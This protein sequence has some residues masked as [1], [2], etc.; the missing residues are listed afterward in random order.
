MKNVFCLKK[1]HSITEAKINY[2]TNSFVHPKRKMAEHDFIYMLEGE[3]KLG[4][5]NNTYNLEKDSLII[6]GANNTH[7]NVSPCLP[8]TKT[9]HF[10]VSCENGDGFVEKDSEIPNDSVYVDIFF[11]FS[12]NKNV[13]KI[14]SEIVSQKLSGNQTKANILFD[15]LLLELLKKQD[16]EKDNRIEFKIKKIIH[17]NPEKFFSNN[18]LAKMVNVS[19]KTAESKFK[20]M[21][22]MTIHQYIL[23][24]KIQQAMLYFKDFPK[25]TIKEIS[26]NL[27]FYDEYHFSKQ[28]KNL[29]G[30]SPSMYK[31]TINL[32]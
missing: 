2:Y 31:K 21:Y 12:G 27:G 5:N 15:M 13:K 14:F 18:D 9:M 25:M 10:H 6:L 16:S 30:I 26:Y 22:K 7:Y 20:A 8:G 23:D 29:V 3:W 1:R 11:D 32:Q 19:V 24:F 17:N 4:Q 28:F